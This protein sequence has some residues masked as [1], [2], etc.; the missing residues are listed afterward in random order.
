MD[1]YGDIEF[2]SGKLLKNGENFGIEI[3]A[4]SIA[5]NALANKF[6]GQVVMTQDDHVLNIYSTTSGRWNKIR[7]FSVSEIHSPSTDPTQLWNSDSRSM[8]TDINNCNNFNLP[9]AIPG[10]EFT[11]HKTKPSSFRI[12]ANAGDKIDNYTY[13]RN[14]TDELYVSCFIKC[15]IPDQWI[16]IHKQG[17]NWV[18]YN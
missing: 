6:N 3:V 11:F 1:T 2:Q 8:F 15:I 16:I 9:N 12:I 4:N 18:S 10:L 5:R 17:T 13:L 14:L 7:N